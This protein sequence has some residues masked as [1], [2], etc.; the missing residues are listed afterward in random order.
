VATCAPHADRPTV[1]DIL[2]DH[3][4]S[5]VLGPDERRVVSHITACRTGVLGGHLGI[6][7]SCFRTHYLSHSCRDRHCPRCGTLDQ[8]LWAE[9]ERAHL[10][11]VAYY[12]VVFTV[13]ESLRP[14]FAGHG[15]ARALDAL[16]AAVTE[17]L[18]EV[19]SSHLHAMLGA[20]QVLHTWTQKLDFHPHIHCLVP[21]GG[22]VRGQWVN[23]PTFLLPTAVLAAVL[24]GKLLERLQHLLD[25]GVF[26]RARYPVRHLLESA[27]RQKWVVY[28]K[29]PLAGP[30]QVIAYFARYVRRIAISDHRIVA[31]DGDTV[32][33]RW[34]DRRSGNTVKTRTLPAAVF[35]RKFLNHVLPPRF[36]RIRR[37]GFLSNRVRRQ[38]LESCRLSITGTA[39]SLA[40][41]PTP[42]SRAQACLR[43]Y[44]RDMSRCAYCDVGRIV[45]GGSWRPSRFAITDPLVAARSPSRTGTVVRA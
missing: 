2:R 38:S 4:A 35:V 11:P 3:A 17:T 15:R 29:K 39:A 8:S 13:P 26:D 43:I 27:A 1:A 6:C 21:G 40:A 18:L 5:L 31:Y 30:D 45:R 10:L 28:A 24:R 41:P 23:R 36:V 7:D 19:G 33:F 12:H 37:V 9:A 34:R 22:L 32:T 14:L 42:E 25:D 16:F 20:L 44:G